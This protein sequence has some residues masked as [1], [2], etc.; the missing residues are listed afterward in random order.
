M[1]RK[2]RGSAS[3]CLQHGPAARR[4]QGLGRAAHPHAAA[5]LQRRNRRVPAAAA[6]RMPALYQCAA[7]SC[8]PCHGTRRF[9]MCSHVLPPVD[10]CCTAQRATADLP[11]SMLASAR[12]MRHRCT[13]WQRHQYLQ[14]H[15]KAKAVASGLFQA[16]H[17][18][19][20]EALGGI[21][22]GRPVLTLAF[23]DMEMMVSKPVVLKIHREQE[24]EQ[25]TSQHALAWAMQN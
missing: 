6:V 15:A 23:D 11:H 2:L 17:S 24:A 1:E 20:Q 10:P 25:Q 7:S 9:L 13:P 18:S 19:S 16:D 14:W 21:L 5:Q 4:G 8:S 3:A 22:G 12:L